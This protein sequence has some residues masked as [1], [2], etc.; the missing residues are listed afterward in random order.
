[1]EAQKITTNGGLRNGK[2]KGGL[3]NFRTKEL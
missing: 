2:T 1:M 3:N